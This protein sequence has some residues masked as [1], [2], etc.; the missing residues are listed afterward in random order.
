MTESTNGKPAST[1]AGTI[2]LAYGKARL[3]VANVSERV[4][5]TVIIVASVTFLGAMSIIAWAPPRDRRSNSD[6][7]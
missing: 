3:K 2:E 5:T 7:S 6:E 1:P 4:Q